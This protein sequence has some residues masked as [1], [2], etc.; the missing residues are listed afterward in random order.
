MMFFTKVS[1]YG[2]GSHGVDENTTSTFMSA[3]PEELVVGYPWPTS[4]LDRVIYIT[5]RLEA[6][7][8]PRPLSSWPS[9]VTSLILSL[10]FGLLEA[11][12]EC[13]LLPVRCTRSFHIFNLDIGWTSESGNQL[14]IPGHMVGPSPP[15]S[16]DDEV[17]Q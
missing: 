8:C 4:M 1:S 14:V 2:V 3:R 16:R 12:L 9:C 15:S 6:E 11:L 17:Y 13:N 5:N 7:T 10:I